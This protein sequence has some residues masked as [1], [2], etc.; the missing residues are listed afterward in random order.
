MKVAVIGAGIM[1]STIGTYL[2]DGGAEVWLSDPF[3]AHVDA[4]NEKGLDIIAYRPDKSTYEKN[5]KNIKAVYSP[6][7]I[8][9][10]VDYIVYCVKM[11]HMDAAISEAACV[12]GENTLHISLLNGV[13]SA[14]KLLEKYP[15]EQ[16]VYG[17]VSSGGA[18]LEPGKVDRNFR[19]GFS[20]MS[21]GPA[22][23][24]IS[25]QLR[26][27][28]ELLDQ[29]DCSF[30]LY[31]DIDPIVWEKMIKN[32]TGNAICAVAR[33]NLGKLYND[34]NGAELSELIEAEV[35]AVAKAQGIEVGPT[36]RM[37]GK[38]PPDFPHVPS[39]AQDVIAKKQTEID[40]INGAVSR[41]GRKYGVPT[42][43]CDCM[44]MLIKLIQANYDHMIL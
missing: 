21:V 41:L 4:I 36:P 43:Y 12:S 6:D 7:M 31:D 29:T 26:V 37:K 13:G 8:G 25:P 40:T 19:P 5:Y 9:E 2:A 28:K 23:K 15:P 30:N 14:E 27:F 1:G 22:S 20:F 32:C 35:R 11:M 33:L 18:I 42:P 17:I 24:S 39:T 16:V 44:T 3:K 34:D 38:L 10:T